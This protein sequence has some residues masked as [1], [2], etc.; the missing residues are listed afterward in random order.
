MKQGVAFGDIDIHQLRS[1]VE[2][3][4]K[5][6]SRI[7][8]DNDKITRRSFT[9]QHKQANDLISEW[10]KN[11]GMDVRIDAIGNV[12]GRVEG[13][14][15][16]GGPALMIGSHLD[17][18]RDAGAY[19][20]ILGV[21]LPLSCMEALNALGIVLPYPVEIIGFCDEEGL[22][23]SS[24]LFG[25]RAIT[26]DLTQEN[27]QERDGDGVSI[28]EAMSSMGLDPQKLENAKRLGEDFLGFLELHIEQG[29]VLEEKGVPVGV[30]TE[31]SGATRY[32][33]ELNGLCGH[34][35]TTPM[36]SRKDALCGA[37]ECII[38][39]ERICKTFDG[40]VGTVGYVQVSPAAGNVIP[41]MANFSLDL[42]AGNDKTRH[43][44][45]CEILK[46]F[47]VIRCS[48]GLGIKINKTYEVSSIA[49]DPTLKEQVAKAISLSGY[50]TIYLSSGA[51]HDA[52]ILAKKMKMAMIFIRC[53]GGISHR[54]DESVTLDDIG[55]VIDVLFNFL[56]NFDYG[57]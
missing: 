24:T 34:A 5:I 20:G 37:A 39:V 18:I 28:A 13:N 44:V 3:R 4:I 1:K 54:P 25:S 26:G 41:G 57:S 48:R 9:V 14:N 43:Q 51:G 55:S 6:L 29:P 17:T 33:I 49:C 56:K 10:M 23:F 38:E 53:L 2:K 32:K 27:L 46:Q 50:E 40:V 45:E 36:N 35:G 8:E 21:V 12:I 42:R 11:A 30:V 22:R 52:M 47:D 7:T 31:I 15:K 16:G 19:D